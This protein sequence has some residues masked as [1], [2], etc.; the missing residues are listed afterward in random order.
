MHTIQV[1]DD[2]LL[3][4]ET[5]N[6]VAA[7]GFGDVRLTVHRHRLTKRIREVKDDIPQGFKEIEHGR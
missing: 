3:V 2:Q 6:K 4:L 7:E 5:Y 1:N